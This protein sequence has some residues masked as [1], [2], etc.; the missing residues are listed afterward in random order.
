MG[1]VF[2]VTHFGERNILALACQNTSIL[3]V[4]LSEGIVMDAGGVSVPL[5]ERSVKVRDSFLD[6]SHLLRMH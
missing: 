1:D 3:L 5:D 4:Q 2:S 6:F